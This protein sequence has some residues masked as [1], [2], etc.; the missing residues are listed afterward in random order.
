MGPA[1][2][3]ALLPQFGELILVEVGLQSSKQCKENSL[4]KGS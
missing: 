2:P 1:G 3:N 4:V